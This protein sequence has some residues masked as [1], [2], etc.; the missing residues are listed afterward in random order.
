MKHYS[1]K[2]TDTFWKIF[3]KKEQSIRH[4]PLNRKAIKKGFM[5]ACKRAGI[6]DF[7]FRDL[8]HTFASLLVMGGVDLVT[9]GNFLGH[10]DI[11][12]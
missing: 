5:G 9:V 3:R 12:R 2:R 8:P 6:T 11:S 1:N 10:K 7:K 4:D